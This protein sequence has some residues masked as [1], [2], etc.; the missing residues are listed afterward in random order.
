[1]SYEEKIQQ[2]QVDSFAEL[3]KITIGDEISYF[4]SFATDVLFQG[5]IYSARPIERSEFQF[6]ERMRSVRCRISAPLNPIFM[7]YVA[8]APSEAVK[9]EIYR[10]FID[11]PDINYI[12]LLGG[13]V[14]SVTI[15]GNMASAECESSSH[16]LKNKIPRFVYQARCNHVLFD[17]GC[18]L[19]EEDFAVPA[20]VTV[21]GS[22]LIASVF[23]LFDDGDFTKGHAKFG[24]DFRMITNHVGNTITLQVPFDS[25]VKSGSTVKVYPGCDGSFSRCINRFDNLVNRLAFDH[26]PSSNPT[27]WGFQ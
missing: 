1:M 3:F 15:E 22:N 19:F 25:R 18:G 8:N 6:A 10:V 2:V 24:T 26:I 23:D 13:E 16:Q 9:V 12:V 7:Q 14:I 17:L 27:I 20:V 21:S 5:N 4:T 11:N